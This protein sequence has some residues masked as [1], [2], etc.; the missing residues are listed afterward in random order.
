MMTHTQQFLDMVKGVGLRVEGC[1]SMNDSRDALRKLL[2]EE[3][4]MEGYRDMNDNELFEAVKR[5]WRERYES[6]C[7]VLVVH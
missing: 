4:E 6:F 3:L 7:K 5:G 1:D 2:G